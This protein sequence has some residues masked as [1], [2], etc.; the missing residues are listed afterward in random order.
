MTQFRIEYQKMFGNDSGEDEDPNVLDSYFVDLPEFRRFN[1]SKEPL[2]LVRARK[3]MGKSAL[4]ARLNYA[5]ERAGHVDIVIKTTGN[6]LLGLGNIQQQ[7]GHATLENYWKQV[8]CKRICMEIGRTIGF[9]GSDDSMSMV[10]TAELEGFK[11]QNLVSALAHRVGKTIQKAIQSVTGLGG[12]VETTKK[13]LVNA[14][15]PLRRYQESKDFLVWL[16]VDDI[17]AKY[18]DNETCMI[19]NTW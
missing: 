6:E 15:E 10:E 13:P 14:L 11:G 3:G 4:L 7:K 9:A 17:D 8:I 12:D 18:V 19:S 5:L 16:L 1:D 2:V